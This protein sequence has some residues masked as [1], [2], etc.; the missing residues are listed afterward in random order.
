M[1][2]PN[3]RRWPEWP[4]EWVEQ[5]IVVEPDGTIVARSGKVEHGQSIRAG[6]VK[7]VGEELDVKFDRVRV[8]L[9]SACRA[10]GIGWRYEVRTDF[11]TYDVSRRLRTYW[12]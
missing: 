10:N 3:A 1:N 4:P 11:H 12:K 5:R 8:E 6:F 7:I 9:R 2:S